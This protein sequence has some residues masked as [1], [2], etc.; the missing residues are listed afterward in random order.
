MSFYLGV[1][2]GTSSIKASLVDERGRIAFTT[3]VASQ[4]LNPKEG[5]FEIDP[6]ETWWKGFLRI[7]EEIRAEYDPKE[8]VSVCVSSVCGSFVP[9][10]GNLDPVYNAIMYGIDTRSREQVARLNRTYGKEYLD[11]KLGGEFTT[12]SVIPKVLWLKENHPEL[13][14][15]ASHFVESN[16]FVSSRLTGE[17]GW[18]YP[19]GAGTRLVDF[20][21]NSL[22]SDL[23]E[24]NGLDIDKFPGLKWPTHILGRVTPSA[25]EKTGLKEGTTVFAGACDINAE[26]MAA[27][28]VNPGDLVVVYG[29][30]ISTILT[31]DRY[32]RLGGFAPGMSLIEN[33]YR[34]GAPTSS[35]ARFLDWMDSFLELDRTFEGSESPT[36]I[37]MLP[38]LDG[39]RAPF[40]NPLARGVFFGV[41]RDTG[42]AE[43]FTAAR[44]AIGYE[45][46]L[47][48]EKMRTVYEI[49]E[50]INSLGGLSNNTG[51]MQL[52][53]NITG[54]KQRIHRGIDAS[55]G[56]AL[57][58]MLRDH[59]LN[60]IFNLEGI[61]EIKDSQEII[62]PD[63]EKMKE[64]VP[65]VEKYLRLYD[66]I[67]KLF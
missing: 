4:L 28:A 20:T 37:L 25:A 36:G 51:L 22:P 52:I 67:E 58:A 34:L 39:A 7:C 31:T 62:I 66:S 2:M 26:A 63:P 3:R 10:D 64:Y 47:L 65:L 5:F 50:T 11:E 53:S 44:E 41:S 24:E 57:I 32:L 19:T 54:K 56:D 49:P 14:K 61:N 48:I 15:K 46:A 8:I 60:E 17:V 18:D 55:Y 33:T 1:D 21:T 16:N 40:D 9:V 13:Y 12:H 35:G 43:F 30:T 45:L 38:Y 23:I 29:S 6:I 59:P 27:R 42:K